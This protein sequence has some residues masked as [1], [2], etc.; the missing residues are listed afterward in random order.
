VAKITLPNGRSKLKYSRQQ[1]AVREWLLTQQ[2]QLR[3]GLLPSNDKVTVAEFFTSYIE[4]VVKHNLRPKTVEAYSSLT[5]LH[6]IPALGKTKLTQLQPEHL[7]NLYSRKL[8][9][10]LSKR[11][12]Q[13]IHSVIHRALQQALKWGIVARNVSDLVDAPR[14]QRRPLS[15][16]SL[17]QVRTFLE[18][19]K[20][21]RF[22]LIYVLAIY[23]AFREGEVLGIHVEDCQIDKGIVNLRHAVQYQLGIGVVITEPKTKLSRRSVKLPKFAVRALKDYLTQINKSQGLIFTTASGRPIN[24]R[25]L[26]KKFKEA[27]S[28]AGLPNIRF[29]DLRHT[30]ATLLLAANVHP[31]LVQE[32]LGHASIVLTMDTYSHVIPNLQDEAADKLDRFLDT[33]SVHPTQ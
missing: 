15:V 13:Y 4:N 11:T 5:K 1:K 33:P 16:Y 20:S 26:V 10:N 8:E 18:S 23:G 14:P 17:E 12:V 27:I 3:Q 21:D 29:H 31:K 6:I 9:E 22:Y 28:V 2:N 25:F 19:T 24:P 32:R 7:Q 30:S